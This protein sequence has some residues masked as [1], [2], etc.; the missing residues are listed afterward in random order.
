MAPQDTAIKP[1]WTENLPVRPVA[2][3]HCR[4][5][6]GPAHGY[7]WLLAPAA[8]PLAA[9]DVVAGHRVVTYRLIHHPHTHLPARDHLGNYL[10][11][12]VCAA[13]AAG[14][15]G[16]P[17]TH[18]KGI[19]MKI[20]KSQIIDLLKNKGDHDSASQAESDLPDQVD[21]DKD[22]G[23]LDKL[24]IDPKDLL[25]KLPGGLGN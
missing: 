18:T 3:D 16:Q 4:A 23:M 1:V 6:G 20:D 5:Y 25:G 14:S 10:Y 11:M 13:S 21:T 22:Q 24:G 19:T 17:G 12:P 9:V 2:E 8:A 15:D 7:S